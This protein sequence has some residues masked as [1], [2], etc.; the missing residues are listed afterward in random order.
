MRADLQNWD[1]PDGLFGWPG[2]VK[3]RLLIAKG[4]ELDVTIKSFGYE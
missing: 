2:G 3:H 4:D 1:A